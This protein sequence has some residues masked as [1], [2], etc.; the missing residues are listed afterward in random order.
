MTARKADLV[1]LLLEQ[2]WE[3]LPEQVEQDG[4]M[5]R[6]L[7]TLLYDRE[8][9]LRWRAVLG[10]GLL[11]RER[12]HIVARTLS[13]LA[14]ALNDEAST[15][16]WMSAPAIGEMSAQ[17]PELTRS[18]VRIVVHY[19]TDLETCHQEN[20]NVELL[21]SALWAI[22]RV[23]S[24]RPELLHEVQESVR[25]FMQDPEPQVRGHA[26]WCAAQGGALCRISLPWARMSR[27]RRFLTPTP[28]FLSPRRW[29]R[30]RWSLKSSA[31]PWGSE[32]PRYPLLSFYQVFLKPGKKRVRFG[33]VPRSKV[34]PFMLGR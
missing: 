2:A 31:R 29:R 3:K 5:L 16:G 17:N 15:C 14:F 28:G 9:L 30:G 22:G 24:R 23:A 10:F 19:I 26:Y 18:V 33:A 8:P 7:F 6:K 25:L 27:E 32:R 21:C 11:A 20:R 4:A 1:R 12:P 34:L 13:R